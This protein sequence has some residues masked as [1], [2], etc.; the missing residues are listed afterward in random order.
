MSFENVKKQI[1]KALKFIQIREDIKQV[2]FSP[3]RILE[4]SI[5]V[6]MDN[7]KIKVFKGFRVQYNSARGPMKGGIRFHPSV[8]LDEVKSLSA[9]MTWKC[10][11]I[12]IP[13]GGAKGGVIVNPKELSEREIEN[14]SRNYIRKIADFI[15]V[16]KDIPAPDV[17][18]NQK[19]MAWM[20][21]EYENI[22]RKKEPGVITGK[23]IS[24]GGSKIR[25]ISTSLGAFY[26]IKD[27]IKHLGLK[28]PTFAIQGFGNAGMNFAR[29]LYENGYIIVGV[30]DSKGG[31]YNEEGLN[32]PELIKFKKSGKSVSEYNGKRISNEEL[33]ELDVDVLA[34]AALGDQITIE[35]ANK[36]KAKYIAE[37]AN[38]PTTPEADE[39]L[40]KRGIFLTPDILTN[41]GGVL[42]SYFEWVQNRM[43]YYWD[44]DEI[45][46]RLKEKMKNA[47]E[48]ILLISNEKKLDMRTAAYVL[49]LKRVVEA[50]EARL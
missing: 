31:I 10:A 39:I 14:L 2:L 32:I 13:F 35:N 37:I 9:L 5:P 40:H 25:N 41:S 21:D 11:V 12:N 18:T 27:A 36:I 8:N 43:G 38:G 34:P 42:V 29:I 26:V 23:P 46:E 3:E 30:S 22:I 49:A 45:K 1:E 48:Q 6:K 20:L 15:G 16:D 47:F 4:V 28:N 50:I 44:E 17:Y 24:I 33:L 7:G 19:I